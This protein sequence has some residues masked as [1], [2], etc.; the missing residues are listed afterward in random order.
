MNGTYGVDFLNKV[1]EANDIIEVAADYF[2]LKKYGDI[3]KTHCIHPGGDKTPSLAFFPNTQSFYCFSC[4][5]GKR[6]GETNGSDV[7][8]FIQWMED[9]TWPEAVE[10]LAD[11]A[12]IDIPKQEMTQEEKDLQVF[13]EQALAENRSYWTNLETQN[14]AEVKGWFHGRGIE[15]EDIAKWRLGAGKYGSQKDLVPVYAIIDEKGRTASFSYRVADEDGKYKNGQTTAIFKKGAI[16]Y[17]LNFI[18]RD[19]R[20]K[21]YLV[22][23]EGYNDAIIL[24][25]YGVPAAAIMST[26]ISGGQIELIKK[27]AKKVIL[28][29]DGDAPGIESTLTNIKRL[30]AEGIEVEVLNIQGSDPDEVCLNY[31]DK[32]W[33]FILDN[34]RLAFHFMTNSI[35]DKYLD[36]SMRLKKEA[37]EKLEE[38]IK[39]IDNDNEKLLYKERIM[40][41]LSHEKNNS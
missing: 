2:T 1:K 5:A 15:D 16:L 25:K 23:V 11:R 6:D 9:L 24:Q 21:E 39:Y 14:G 27:Y 38:V 30:S 28:F 31:K 40:N 4:H 3:Y 10:H 26:S 8:S 34:K 35:L 12:G 33:D 32:M 20:Q 13:Y 22:L 36:E 18:K 17:G 29:L 37:L 19:I 41:I 7:I